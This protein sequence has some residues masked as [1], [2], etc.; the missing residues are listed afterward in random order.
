MYKKY[1]TECAIWKIK[2]NRGVGGGDGATLMCQ[3]TR[4]NFSNHK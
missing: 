4:S 2:E 3:I 1:A